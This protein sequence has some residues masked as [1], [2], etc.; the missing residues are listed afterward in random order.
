MRWIT[1]TPRIPGCSMPAS[2]RPARKLSCLKMGYCLPKSPK[3]DIYVFFELFITNIRILFSSRSPHYVSQ[4]NKSRSRDT[5]S[6]DITIMSNNAFLMPAD[7]TYIRNRLYFAL[8]ANYPD[9]DTAEVSLCAVPGFESE[10]MLHC[11][12]DISLVSGNA[13]FGESIESDI[14]VAIDRA[15]DRSCSKIPGDVEPKWQAFSRSGAISSSDNRLF[16]A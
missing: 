13:V 12:V 7:E 14:Y 2:S 5:K 11:R 6:M 9:I 15:V 3:F 10:R 8:A 4:L 16:S 1:M